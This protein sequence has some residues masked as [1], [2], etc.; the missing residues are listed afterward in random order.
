MARQASYHSQDLGSNPR[1]PNFYLILY[2]RW[3]S[4]YSNLQPTVHHSPCSS[5]MAFGQIWW[6]GSESPPWS[7]VS[8][9]TPN[10]KSQ[11]RANTIRLQIV[12][13]TTKIRPKPLSFLFYLFSFINCF[14]CFILISNQ[15]KNSF[16]YKIKTT[17]YFL[18]IILTNKAKQPSGERVHPI[19]Y[20]S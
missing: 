15:L 12:I 8:A 3:S 13:Y 1:S 2:F 5:Q 11:R 20:K 6:P 10:P 16:L 4:A 18:C 17:K 7:Q 9:C 19:S 14:Y